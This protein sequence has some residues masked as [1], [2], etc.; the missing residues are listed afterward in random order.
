LDIQRGKGIK[1]FIKN[2]TIGVIISSTMVLI[3]FKYF[4]NSLPATFPYICGVGGAVVTCGVVG[5]Q[6]YAKKHRNNQKG[7]SGKGQDSIGI[8]ET[9]QT[10]GSDLGRDRQENRTSLADMTVDDKRSRVGKTDEHNETM[11]IRD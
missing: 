7:K 2:C 3:G 1:D 8:S 5:A 11:E 6:E 4:S 9:T 10:R